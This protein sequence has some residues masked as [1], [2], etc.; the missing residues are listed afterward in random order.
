MPT[1]HDEVN[2]VLLEDKLVQVWPDYF[3]FAILTMLI[4]VIY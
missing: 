3:G 2:D 4:T 1:I